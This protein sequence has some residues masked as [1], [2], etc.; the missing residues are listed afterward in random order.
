MELPIEC[1]G[2]ECSDGKDQFEV[3]S[4]IKNGENIL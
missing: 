4:S 2:T 3:T 1:F